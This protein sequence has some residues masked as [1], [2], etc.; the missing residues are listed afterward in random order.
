MKFCRICARRG[1]ER[2]AVS[3]SLCDRHIGCLRPDTRRRNRV[4]APLEKAFKAI[5]DAT[6]TGKHFIWRYTYLLGFFPDAR[7]KQLKICLELDEC[8]VHGCP[9]CGHADGWAKKQG[10]LDQDKKKNGALT[11]N[12]QTVVRIWEHQV[13]ADANDCIKQL[14][15]ICAMPYEE[16]RGKVMVIG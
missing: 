12:G 14:K 5:L 3:N 15:T 16:R 10:R 11:H 4:K 7:A 6:E 1:R 8:E 13:E 9:K 2:E